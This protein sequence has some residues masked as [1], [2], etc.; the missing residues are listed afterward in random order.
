MLFKIGATAVGEAW[1]LGTTWR[2]NARARRGGA[3][4]GASGD[5]PDAGRE[6]QEMH[7][8]DGGAAPDEAALAPAPAPER[9]PAPARAAEQLLQGG[10]EGAQLGPATR[11]LLQTLAP[12][13][14]AG[15]DELRAEAAAAAREAEAAREAVA[16]ARAEAEAAEATLDALSARRSEE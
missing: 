2:R 3:A 11:T 14:E 10:D 6:M 15:A 1:A 4:A 13:E 16:R 9:A 5:A 7:S 12:A 8:A